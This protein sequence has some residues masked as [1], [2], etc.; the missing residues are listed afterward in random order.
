MEKLIRCTRCNK[1]IPRYQG[2]GDFG[3]ISSLPG[4]EW[5]SEDLDEQK[6]FFKDHSNHLLEELLIDPE[7]ISS[8]RPSY[9]SSKISHME[10]SNGKD[11]FLIRRV[12]QGFSRPAFYEIIPGPI[13]APVKPLVNGNWGQDKAS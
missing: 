13:H 12:K 8:D 7:T 4:V 10:A 9:E 6:I 1:V 5:C 3:E 11:R 2:Y